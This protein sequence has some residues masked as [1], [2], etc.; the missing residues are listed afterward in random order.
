MNCILKGASKEELDLVRHITAGYKDPVELTG[1]EGKVAIVNYLPL[2]EY[3]GDH[4]NP[5]VLF[6]IIGQF[7]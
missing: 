3:V 5:K 7:T 6:G 1:N 2:S 4:N